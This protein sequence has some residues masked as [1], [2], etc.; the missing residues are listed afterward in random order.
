MADIKASQV[1]QLRNKTGLS[2]MEC[3]KA[4]VEAGGDE[5]AALEILR[6][7]GADKASKKAERTTGSGIIEAYSHEGRIGVLVEVLC[8]TDFVTRNEEFKQLAHDVALQVAAMNPLYVSRDNVPAEILDEQKKIFEDEARSGGKPE[9]IIAKIAEGK[10]E[11]YFAEVCLVDQPFVKD[12]D[13]TIGKLITEKIAKIGE[14]IAV[15]RF[16]RFELGLK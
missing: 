6:R 1:A 8:E 12:Q 15:S 10:L 14:N 3:K 7:S 9:D 2:M 16:V 5:A 13:T 4:L 11:K